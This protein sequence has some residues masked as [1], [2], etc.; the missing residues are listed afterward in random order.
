MSGITQ[1]WSADRSKGFRF[2]SSECKK[3]AAYNYIVQNDG[4][5]LFIDWYE[6]YGES[7]SKTRK[8]ADTEMT[9]VAMEDRVYQYTLLLKI[10][11]CISMMKVSYIK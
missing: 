5:M 1:G 11:L 3:I 2:Q 6:E 7:S 10:K 9:V 8:V 4:S